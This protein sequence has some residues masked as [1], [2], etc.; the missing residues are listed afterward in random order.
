MR[1]CLTVPLALVC[2]MFGLLQRTCKAMK[3]LVMA[4]SPESRFLVELFASHLFVFALATRDLQSEPARL[5][6]TAKAMA[7]LGNHVEPTERAASRQENSS[8]QVRSANP[9][10]GMFST[11]NSWRCQG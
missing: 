11:R 8:R 1:R 9:A 3:G 10:C 4:A 7:Q 2:F 6:C 5:T